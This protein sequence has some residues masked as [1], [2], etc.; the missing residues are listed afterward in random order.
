[1]IWE[2]PFAE[3]GQ[4]SRFSLAD[5]YSV[6]YVVRMIEARDLQKAFRTKAGPVEAVRGVDLRVQEGE[7]VAFLGPNGAGKT[8]T[9]RMLTTLL[10]PTSGSARV[11][12]YDITDEAAR[13]R[14]RI[15]FIGQGNSAGYY[16]RIRDELVIQGRAYGLTWRRARHRADELLEVMELTAL[17]DRTAGTLSGGQRRRLDVALGLV[18]SPPLLFLDEPSTG[19]DP[20]TRARLWEQLLELRERQGT[21]IFL[22]THYLEEADTRAERVIIVD[23]GRV[24]ADDTPSALKRGL[25]GDLVRLRVKG[26]TTAAA[27]VV[28]ALPGVRDLETSGDWI[29]ARLPD[30]S[31]AVPPLLERIRAHDAEV[32]EVEVLPPTLDDVFLALTG[33][34]LRE[35]GTTQTEEEMTR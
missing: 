35:E 4:Q 10:R 11:A 31:T 16:H 27:A 19:L 8:T 23:H 20:Q 13:V 7:L 30:G 33:R 9:L 6:R 15:G 18:H 34:S 1:M 24:I 28:E 29:T 3:R 2:S 17:A 5:A 14:Q 22:T 32:V 12:G 21:T 26:S 25:A